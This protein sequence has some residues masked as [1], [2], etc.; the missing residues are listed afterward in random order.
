MHILSVVLLLIQ[1]AAPAERSLDAGTWV[2]PSLS[3]IPASVEECPP[4]EVFEKRVW[5]RLGAEI[6]VHL[7]A[8][9]RAEAGQQKSFC[10]EA[11]SALIARLSGDW[12]G[13]MSMQRF[14][15]ND[16][17]AG[18]LQNMR[19]AYLSQANQGFSQTL[20]QALGDTLRGLLAAKAL[21]RS[22]HLQS[23]QA[24][25]SAVATKMRTQDVTEDELGLLRGSA[26]ILALRVGSL[27]VEPAG[28]KQGL[29]FRA[30]FQAAIWGFDPLTKTFTPEGAFQQSGSESARS[31]GAAGSAVADEGSRFADNILELKP[32][33]FTTQILS[34]NEGWWLRPASRFTQNTHADLTMNH[35]FRYLETRAVTGGS[36]Q[37]VQAGYG[38]CDGRFPQDS[39]WRLRHIGGIKPYSGLVLEEIPGNTW[40]IF[41]VA[42]VGSELDNQS[43]TTSSRGDNYVS[44]RHTSP[45]LE[46]RFSGRS[47]LG[48]LANQFFVFDLPIYFGSVA[49][50]INQ[51]MGNFSAPHDSIVYHLR[52]QMPTS[53]L[54]GFGLEPG[55]T[56]RVPIRRLFFTGGAQVGLR[57]NFVELGS[58]RVVD[59][60]GNDWTSTYKQE[61]L[62]LTK[63]DIRELMNLDGTVSVRGGLEW[64]IT[65]WSGIGLE[66]MYDVLRGAGGMD[67]RVGSVDNG[68]WNS[69]KGATT[70]QGRLRWMIQYVWK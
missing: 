53:L 44:L 26:H 64:S 4:Y 13:L 28:R 25:N 61:D 40:G 56:F 5:I 12:S 27:D 41:S 59:Q 32:F 34:G 39:A 21:E 58:E 65:P 6:M 33:R 29:E 14:D 37:Q 18:L 3:V 52:S 42:W 43:D 16:L 49:G 20:G 70:G 24:Q 11:R 38:Y 62:P 22:M 67:Y 55:W 15:H 63:T 35:R 2:R 50:S 1:P 23:D 19:V 45:L 46:F 9:A 69:V 47:N 57:M 7:R 36:D 66:V 31:G 10:D 8:Q 48:N 51:N 30:H 54:W 68:D 17:P 60:F